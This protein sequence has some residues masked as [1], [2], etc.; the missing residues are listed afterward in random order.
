MDRRKFIKNTAIA[1]AGLYVGSMVSPSM[2]WGM[3]GMARKSLPAIIGGESVHPDGWPGW[4][5]WRDEYDQKVLDVLRSGSWFRAGVT[6]EFEKQWAEMLGVKRALTIANGTNSLIT[7]L[8]NMGVTAG[9]EVITTPYTFVATVQA[10]LNCGAIPVFADIDRETF[11]IDPVQIEK[12]ITPRTKAILPVH[13]LGMPADMNRI[14]AIAKKHNL[15]VIEDTCQ[16]HLAEYDGKKLGTIADAGCFSFQNSKNLP[17]GEGGAVVSNDEVFMDR[18]FSYHNQGFPY[19]TQLGEWGGSFM[20]GTNV[21]LSE[22]QSMVGLVQ[23]PYMVEQA[24]TRWE[25]GKYLIEQ[26]KGIPGIT[27]IKLYKECTKAVFHLFPY[28]Y[29]PEGFEGMPRE[30]FIEAMNAE[31]IPTV[32]GYTPLHTEPFIKSAFESTLYKKVYSPEQIDYEAYMAAN[33]CPENDAICNEE[34]IWM[35][36]SMLLADK[37]SMDD[38]A[39]SIAKI[40]KHAGSIMRKYNKG[41]IG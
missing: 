31:G 30:L 24:N 13:I 22:Y 14:M 25:N 29:N 18:C 39:E 27:P 9:D 26:I 20:I 1:G 8:K 37:S 19:G 34:S 40:Q 2:L 36:Q 28:R 15:I 12:K 17:I 4:P 35:S 23:L 6:E 5:L 11:Q 32:A 7:A 16:S 21:R 38:I 41:E 10:I 33:Q 3:N